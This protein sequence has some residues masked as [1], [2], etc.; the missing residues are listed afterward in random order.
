MR[1]KTTILFSL[2]A[3]LGLA[4][5]AFAAE[6]QAMAGAWL[7]IERRAIASH[8]M[9]YPANPRPKRRAISALLW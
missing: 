6:E 3:S 4:N 8:A 2:I 7:S 1:I 5:M 9:R